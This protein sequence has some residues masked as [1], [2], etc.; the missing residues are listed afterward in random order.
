MLDEAAAAAAAVVVIVVAAAHLVWCGSQ[1]AEMMLSLSQ[2]HAEVLLLP[3]PPAAV[4][5]W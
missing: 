3:R 1:R 2:G 4:V 5:V